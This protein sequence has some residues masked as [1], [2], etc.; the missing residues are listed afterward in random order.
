MTTVD[1][2]TLSERELRI[3]AE[4]EEELRADGKLDR[5]LSTMHPGL[6]SR[7]G[8]AVQAAGRVSP[9][10]P[11]V[12]VMLSLS[13]ALAAPHDHTVSALVVFSVIWASTVLLLG[14][15]LAVHRATRAGGDYSD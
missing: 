5:E 10:V 1:G 7:A 11:I 3:L 13:L 4:I 8:R 2:P 9:A 6:P 14:A 12:L 15:R